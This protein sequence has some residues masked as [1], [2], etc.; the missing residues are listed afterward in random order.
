MVEQPQTGLE[1]ILGKAARA[2]S[3]VA[4][5]GARVGEGASKVAGV[6]GDAVKGYI[7]ERKDRK[8][9]NGGEA[10][11]GFDEAAVQDGQ[12][13]AVQKEKPKRQGRFYDAAREAGLIEDPEGLYIGEKG[14]K[15]NARLATQ[16]ALY[17][18]G[19]RTAELLKPKFG[20]NA[21]YEIVRGAFN[22]HYGLVLPAAEDMEKRSTEKK[23]AEARQNSVIS[24]A[25]AYLSNTK[26]WSIYEKISDQ[27][28]KVKTE[29][30]GLTII[31]A[32]T[33]EELEK[34]LSR[35][36]LEGTPI[37]YV[38]SGPELQ[39]AAA[40]IGVG[41]GSKGLED[42]I[43]IL[44]DG[45]DASRARTTL[46]ISNRNLPEDRRAAIKDYKADEI[47]QFSNYLVDKIRAR[48]NRVAE[49]PK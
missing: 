28:R 20:E 19:L 9:G 40:K 2:A 24:V 4:K 17:D 21:T 42:N 36:V 6:T 47:D 41:K 30:P 45:N 35:K 10:P 34:S 23:R 15:V 32:S 22:K 1:R 7:Q 12:E 37:A 18:L 44:V 27:L 16:E 38:L 13:E 14:S 5:V 43:V 46:E 48:V 3:V 29:I 49:K 33:Y 39:N 26:D 25:I 8:N 11:K 31:I